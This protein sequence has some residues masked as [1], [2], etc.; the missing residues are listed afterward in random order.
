[1]YDSHPVDGTRR[2]TTFQREHDKPRGI[3]AM[4]TQFIR[5]QAKSTNVYQS[6]RQAAV[7]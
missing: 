6:A 5:R 4:K 2:E 1:M 3:S 7:S